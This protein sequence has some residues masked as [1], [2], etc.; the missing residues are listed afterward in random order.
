MGQSRSILLDK[1][2]KNGPSKIGRNPLKKLKE[3]GLLKQ[4]K[5]CL[6]QILH[7]PFFNTCALMS[8]HIFH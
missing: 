2:F 7:G 5:G 8:S 6:P 1:V 4:I 3:Y